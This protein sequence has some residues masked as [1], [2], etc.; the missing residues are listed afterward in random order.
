MNPTNRAQATTQDSALNTKA[1]SNI[2]KSNLAAATYTMAPRIA[3][4]F[5]ARQG[6]INPQSCSIKSGRLMPVPIKAERAVCQPRGLNNKGSV[7]V[8]ANCPI[9]KPGS[10][11]LLP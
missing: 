1:K 8:T 5:C 3:P 4:G 2:T 7:I 9:S 10:N 6:R 11:F